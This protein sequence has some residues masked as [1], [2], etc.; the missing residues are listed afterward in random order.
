MGRIRDALLEIAAERG[1]ANITVREITSAAGVSTRSFYKHFPSKEACLFGV[2]QLVVQRV[3]R[4]IEDA[5]RVAQSGDRRLPLIVAAIVEEWAS[6][7]R[8]ARLMLID[9]YAAGP[10][11][12]KR[13]RL[14]T[15]SL[16][17][18]IGECLDYA[19][20]PADLA[21]L[22]AEGIVAGIF[23]ATRSC[24]LRGKDDLSDIAEPLGRWAAAYH[25]LRVKQIEDALRLPPLIPTSDGT[26]APLDDSER[27]AVAEGDRA[28]LLAAAARL[29]AS[30]G[31]AE[32]GLEEIAST[33][34]IPR[35][36]FEAEFSDLEACLAAAH[37][38]Q[39]DRAIDRV[40]RAEKRHGHS[41]GA[42]AVV[43]SLGVQR[44]TDPALA[45]LCFSDVALSGPQLLRSHQRFMTRVAGLITDTPPA[46]VGVGAEASAGALWR[47]LRRRVVMGRKTQVPEIVSSLASLASPP[48]RAEASRLSA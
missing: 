19:P 29:V 33:A 22:A 5:S 1:Y 41:G 13:A 25:D 27:G 38:L 35:R 26:S 46:S 4:S 34:G 45:A 14:A 47:R 11:A 3:L 48:S 30:R 6:D 12:L 39:A 2:H 10:L 9:A 32:L 42:S 31:Q 7:P 20:G 17:A 36:G 44:T 24:I 18:R 15:R 28:L 40:E 23:T 21:P 16:E 8:A 37:R 43:A